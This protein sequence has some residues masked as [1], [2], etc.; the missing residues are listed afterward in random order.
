MWVVHALQRWVDY[1]TLNPDAQLSP[2]NAILHPFQYTDDQRVAIAEAVK[3]M[4]PR[5]FAAEQFA[6]IVNGPS[7]PNTI[8]DNPPVFNHDHNEARSVHRIIR[9]MHDGECPACGRIHPAE[10][11]LVYGPTYVETNTYSYEGKR[12][13]TRERLVIAWKCPSCAFEIDA[14][15]AEAG[16]MKF[17]KFMLENLNVFKKWAEQEFEKLLERDTARMDGNAM[18]FDRVP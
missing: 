18:D 5:G 3:K 17:R 14:K 16:L 10:H 15:T 7:G 13:S 6:E 11:M 9:A 4:Q 8:T 2:H 1:G 12:T